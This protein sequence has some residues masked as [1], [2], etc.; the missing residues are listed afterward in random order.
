M[1]GTAGSQLKEELQQIDLDDQRLHEQLQKTKKL[2]ANA[3]IRRES[4]GRQVENLNREFENAKTQAESKTRESAVLL[5]ERDCL[6]RE[7][8]NVE[9]DIR[10]H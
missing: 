6:A 9:E 1:L 2:L 10:K 7:Q 3:G 4:Y 5:D 8:E